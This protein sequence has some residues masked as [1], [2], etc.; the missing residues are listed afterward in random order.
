MVTRSLSEEEEE[1]RKKEVLFIF[2][3]ISTTIAAF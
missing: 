3:N 2:I 1:G